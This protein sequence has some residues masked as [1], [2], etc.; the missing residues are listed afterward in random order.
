MDKDSY[1][2]GNTTSGPGRRGYRGGRKPIHPLG[3]ETHP[4]MLRV[5]DAEYAIAVLLG[6]GFATKGIRQALALAA[7]GLPA[8][9]PTTRDEALAH[10]RALTAEARRRAYKA[11]NGILT[12]KQAKAIELTEEDYQKLDRPEPEQSEPEEWER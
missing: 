12:P 6:N 3:T 7:P 9:S 4:L 2:R 10:T 8:G 1:R 5:S 11:W